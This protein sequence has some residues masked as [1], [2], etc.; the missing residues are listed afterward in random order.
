M[1]P[2]GTSNELDVQKEWEEN[3]HTPIMNG[4]RHGTWEESRKQALDLA[5]SMEMSKLTRDG[6]AEPVSRD[7]IL[8]LERGQRIIHF[9]CSAADHEQDRQLCPDVRAIHTNIVLRTHT[10]VVTH[11]YTKYACYTTTVTNVR[12]TKWKPC[13]YLVHKPIQT[14]VLYQYICMYFTAHHEQV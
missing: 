2:A 11:I 1:T 8:R 12:V 4:R 3:T 6:T 14:A 10:A 7:Q 9:L 5:W 13:W